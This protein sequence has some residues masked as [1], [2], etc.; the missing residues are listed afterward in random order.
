MVL[1]DSE[2]LNSLVSMINNGKFSKYQG[3]ALDVEECMETGLASLFLSAMAAAKSKD[4]GTIVSV[5]HSSPYGC[6]DGHDLMTAFFAD[7]NIDYISPQ[8]YTSGDEISPDFDAITV[9]W[10]EYKQS[11]ASLLPSIVDGTQYSSAQKYFSDIGIPISGYMQWA[12]KSAQVV[13]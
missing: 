8:L 13:I 5:S 1:F 10:D 9:A 12:H 11:R 7:S 2:K 4:L 6:S 3:I